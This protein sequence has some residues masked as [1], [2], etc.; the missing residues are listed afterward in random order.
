M[1]TLSVREVA[2]RGLTR[3]RVVVADGRGRVYRVLAR[4]RAEALRYAAYEHAAL[5]RRRFGRTRWSPDQ[6][7]PA[8]GYLFDRTGAPYVVTVVPDSMVGEDPR[9]YHVVGGGVV[10]VVSA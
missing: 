3:W 10:H 4:D 6:D 2:R 1:E 8:R 7:A 9:S 5:N